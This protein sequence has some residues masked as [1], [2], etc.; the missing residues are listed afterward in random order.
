[1]A[2]YPLPNPLGTVMSCP[3][4]P[5]EGVSLCHLGIAHATRCA[6]LGVSNGAP[7]ARVEGELYE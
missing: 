6:I 2:F 1:M 4:P 5:V 7:S 3:P